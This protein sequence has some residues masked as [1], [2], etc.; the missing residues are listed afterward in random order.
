MDARKA[1]VGE[2]YV[3]YDAALGE[4]AANRWFDEAH[5]Q[6]EGQLLRE[7]TGR[8]TVLVLDRGGEK[9]VLR[10]YHRG[11]LVSRF[12]HDHY[13]WAGLERS[14]SFREW[15][16]LAALHDA[17]LPAPR[18]V[19]A[20]VRRNALL[21]QA[22]IIT[23]YLPDTRP[24]SVYL[25]EGRP[26]AERWREIGRM[27]RAF[28]DRGVDHPD[29]TAHNILLDSDGGTFLVDFDNARLRPPGPWRKA[30]LERLERSL[31]KV[32][33]ETGTSF[34]DEGWERLVAGYDEPAAAARRYGETRSVSGS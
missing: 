4:P 1:T 14:R 30:G 11:G 16:L 6:R 18:P 2:S 10:H 34:D 29:L 12:I 21:Y 25:D 24:L 3:L 23:A 32:A 5:W 8:G 15:R 9:W 20:R 17:G 13:I 33:L 19:A 26:L 28:H 7:K 22:D 31:R 27:L